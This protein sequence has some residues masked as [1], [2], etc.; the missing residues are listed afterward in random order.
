V[1][2]FEVGTTDRNTFFKVCCF[3][4]MTTQKQC[5]QWVWFFRVVE[6]EN[7]KYEFFYPW[8][9]NDFR[10]PMWTRVNTHGDRK[11]LRGHETIRELK[12]NGFYRVPHGRGRLFIRRCRI[13]FSRL[14]LRN[15]LS[16]RLYMFADFSG[17]DRSIILQKKFL[18]GTKSDPRQKKINH[19]TIREKNPEMF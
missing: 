17:R 6:V 14:W 12:R 16:W 11:S 2:L 9:R 7:K 10:S 3:R 13:F 19:E 5:W 15:F 4:P 1:F 18:C 8:P